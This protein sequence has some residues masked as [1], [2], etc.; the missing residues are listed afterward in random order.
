MGTLQ[1][2]RM[3]WCVRAARDIASSWLPLFP[4][5]LSSRG[6]SQAAEHRLR[7]RTLRAQAAG[8][9][10]NA[11]GVLHSRSAG[12]CLV[13]RALLPQRCPPSAPPPPRPATP[14]LPAGAV[15]Q[16]VCCPKSGSRTCQRGGESLQLLPGV[17]CGVWEP[18]SERGTGSFPA[19]VLCAREQG[20]QLSVLQKW[21]VAC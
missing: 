8:G 9:V 20:Q 5:M 7:Y 15:R 16:T 13:P 2:H 10:R 11:G 12:L 6:F 21:G 1:Y 14:R 19:R 4:R 3:L 18:P 17:S